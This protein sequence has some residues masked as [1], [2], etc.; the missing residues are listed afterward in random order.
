MTRNILALDRSSD[1]AEPAN[2]ARN[3]GAEDVWWPILPVEFLIAQNNGSVHLLDGS[4]SAKPETMD[5]GGE[6]HQPGRRVV[7]KQWTMVRK[8]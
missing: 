1:V 2:T 4:E 5:A 8:Y 7:A 6:S 3:D